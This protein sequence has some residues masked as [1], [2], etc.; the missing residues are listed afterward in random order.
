MKTIILIIITGFIITA[1]SCGCPTDEE[2]KLREDKIAKNKDSAG[3]AN[4][5]N[6]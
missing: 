6:K 3:V 1:Y 2:R 5:I 4:E